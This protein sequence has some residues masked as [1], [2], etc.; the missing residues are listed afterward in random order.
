MKKKRKKSTIKK[1]VFISLI[2]V[3]AG[4]AIW[5]YHAIFADEYMF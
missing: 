3:L 2:L 1:K 5:G 4:M